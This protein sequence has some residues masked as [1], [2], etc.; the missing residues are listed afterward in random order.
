MRALAG[1]CAVV[2]AL[3]AAGCGE[4]VDRAG[5]EKTP[6]PSP[7]LSLATEAVEVTQ[8]QYH[9][10]PALRMANGL[11][12]VVAVPDIGGRIM[13]YKLNGHPFLWSNPDEYG[14]SYPAPKTE[15]ERAWHNFGGYKVWPAPQSEWKGPPDPVGSS[16]DGGKWTGEIVQRAGQVGEIKL[17]SPA[18]SAVTGLQ[19]TRV[20]RLFAG[21]TRVEVSETFSNVS[22][23]DIRWSVW[24][25]TQVPGALK[26][27]SAGDEES[28]I[29]FPINPQSKF[30]GGFQK[31]VADTAGDSQWAVDKEHGLVKVSYRHQ[32]GKIGADSAAGWIAHV[33]EIHNLAYI[34]RFPVEKLGEYPDQGSTVEVY[35]NGGAPYME[36][37]VL[38][39]VVALKP[40]QEQTV[41]RNWYATSTPGPVREANDVGV[42]QKPLQCRR[43]GDKLKVG[44][45][46]GVFAEGTVALS[47]AD[48]DGRATDEITTLPAS[49]T[50]PLSIDQA[51]PAPK[52]AAGLVL[53]LRNANGAP[54]GELAR[55]DLPAEP[56]PQVAQAA[57]K[58]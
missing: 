51:L 28:R 29:Y 11:V 55:A 1:A 18:D 58:P 31:L 20:V 25:V 21:G 14:K 23:R 22:E 30:E 53:V 40:G 48:Q 19:I 49:P 39:P 42:T 3:L 5:P 50:A 26:D 46:F 36:V 41:V 16:L 33:D 44:G 52:G 27:G 37:E 43:D 8:V 17:V 38:S 12:T 54:L 47:W 2:I 34:K 10:W 57:A 13:E 56:K 35:T 9:G 15:S 45:T 7:K 32:T 4:D 6:T 24:D